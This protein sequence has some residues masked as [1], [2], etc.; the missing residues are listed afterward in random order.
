[1]TTPPSFI[2]HV[3]IRPGMYIGPTDQRA[4]YQLVQYACEAA[5]DTTPLH[6]CSHISLKITADHCIELLSD[7]LY[8]EMDAAAVPHALT[9]L[10]TNPPTQPWSTMVNI[11]ILNAVAE[12]FC[13]DLYT[14]EHH[15]SQQ[16][17]QGHPHNF[18][19]NPGPTTRVGRRITFVPDRGILT[20]WDSFSAYPIMGYLRTVAA[21]H[22]G[23]HVALRDERDGSGM[24][25]VY[26]AGIRG[27]LD[28]LTYAQI[29]DFGIYPQFYCRQH[30][31]DITAEVALQWGYGSAPTIWSYV[32]GHATLDGGTHV[33]GLRQ[34]LVQAL[35]QFARQEQLFGDDIPPL[36]SQDLPRT[37]AAI[38]AI[39]AKDPQ[40]SGA[41][42][43]QLKDQRIGK[44]IRHML[45]EQ[46]PN[47]FKIR[48]E[49]ITDWVTRYAWLI[50]NPE[51]ER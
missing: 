45:I 7:G 21:L 15:V 22:A 43:R 44:F 35:D 24:E 8:A 5:L 27:Y 48:A 47:Q 3:R 30:T 11:A 17:R 32:N 50:R 18:V 19:V 20:Q 49:G 31:V 23:L 26:Q 12:Q 25:I 10:A 42:K 13:L 46:L 4:V 38:I 29:Y 28:E 51:D 40:Y 1:M 2:K 16:F 6:P 14:G 34:G 36:R 41:M 33:T 37:L 39:Q 9:T